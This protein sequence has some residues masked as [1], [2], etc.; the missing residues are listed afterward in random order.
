MRNA[1]RAAIFVLVVLALLALLGAT[2]GAGMMGVGMMDRYG[3]YR[4]GNFGGWAWGPGMGMGMGLLGMLAFWA[5]VVGGAIWLFSSLTASSRDTRPREETP[6]DILK[7]RFAAG[8][9]T[10]EDYERMRRTLEL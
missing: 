5:A 2:I 8:E 10:A 1:P 3:G 4:T 7:R 9:I 6:L